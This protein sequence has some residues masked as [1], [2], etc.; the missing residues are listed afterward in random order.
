MLKNSPDPVGVRE[1]PVRDLE[2]P[3]PPHAK[4]YYE[5]AFAKAYAFESLE[6][7]MGLVIHVIRNR[8]EQPTGYRLLIEGKEI[9]FKS[10][11][12][13]KYFKVADEET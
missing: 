8:L 2:E 11:L 3:P 5:N 6:G 10:K 9:F 7:K 1:L 12:A 13:E 4:D